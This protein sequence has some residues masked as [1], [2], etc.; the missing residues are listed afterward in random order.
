MTLNQLELLRDYIDR[1][2]EER[3]AENTEGADGYRSSVT[4]EQ[5]ARISAWDNLVDSFKSN[6]HFLTNL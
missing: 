5:M 1:R 6:P 2:I 4:T 3:E